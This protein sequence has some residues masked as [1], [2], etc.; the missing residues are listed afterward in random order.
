MR[1]LILPV[2]LI[3]FFACAVAVAAA[4]VTITVKVLNM[5]GTPAG[6]IPVSLQNGS[7]ASLASGT[8]NAS[9]MCAFT[10]DPRSNV[11]RALI[12]GP[13]VNVT[14]VWHEAVDPAIEV[15]LPQVGEVSGTI[16]LD[17]MGAGNPLIVLDD[18]IIYDS[19]PYDVSRQNGSESYSFKANRFS[20]ATT[21]GQH[22]L[23]AVGY[24]DGVVY[25]S[26][27]LTV[28][29]SGVNSPVMLELKS[30][31]GNVSLFSPAVYERIF[32]TS[33]AHGGLVSMAGTLIGADGRP[34][35]NASL[36][37]QDYFLNEP[38]TTVTGP[39]GSFAFATMN[40][41]TDIVRFRAVI[42]DNGTYSS[43]SPFYPAQNT[44]GLEVKIPDYPRSAVGY[45]YGIIASTE[46][47]SNPV[48]VSGTV[49]L[50][51]GLAQ[52]VSPDKDNGRFF[53]T[54][55]PG[56]YEIYAEHVEG[57]QSLVSEKRRIVV[58]PV[59]SPLAVD[60]TVLVVE[61]VKVQLLPL[62]AA[63]ISGVLLI[64][65]FAYANRKWL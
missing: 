36:T 28:N 58:E 56:S 45:V 63:L 60:P 46:N 43:Y 57:G 12:A 17:G 32:H 39:D 29:V 51:N 44:T 19:T 26:D 25:M 11:V 14:S 7:Y 10:I 2:I 54:L 20:F 21:A 30:A 1:R 64:A 47:R 40:L 49:Y 31:G 55:A 62:L 53:F 27:R 37:A 34:V 23:Y 59:W 61:P 16:K 52:A 18:S 50:S 8:T 4:P 42:T 6:G 35:A 41:S 65:M 13:E 9:G 38:G 33:E 3:L 15:R 48:P 5:D 24:S 22:V